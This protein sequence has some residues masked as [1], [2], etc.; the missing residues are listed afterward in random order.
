MNA[1][2]PDTLTMTAP[3]PHGATRE[4]PP[5][6]FGPEGLDALLDA[7]RADGYTTVGPRLRDGAVVYDAITR[8]ADLP[9]GWQ[10]T[11]EPASSRLAKTGGRTFFGVT[12]GAHPWKRFFYPPKTQVFALRRHGR[13]FVP[14][15]AVMAPAPRYALIG[16]RACELVAIARQD[17]VLR[18]GFTPDPLYT[19][20]RADSFIV[21]VN[22]TR[23]VSTCFCVSQGT[24]PCAQ[25]GY[26]LA[27]TEL[28]DGDR[29]Q[30][31]CDIGTARGA[32]VL[33]RISAKA[34]TAT[35]LH[36]AEHARL[37]A[38]AQTRRLPAAPLLHDTLLARAEHPHWDDIARRCMSCGACTVSCPTCF[39]STT[40]DSTDIPGDTLTRWRLWDSCFSL[41]FSYI[42]GGSV[43][44]SGR[45]RYRQWMTHKLATW[46]DQFGSSGCVGC[47]RCIAWCP[48][49]IDI[50]AEAA[51]LTRPHEET[52]HAHS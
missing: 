6:V 17:R 47:G 52:V 13:S 10:D 16:P 49:G 1:H 38:E 7:L 42:H 51:A 4:G 41:D 14:V 40:T 11:Q 15:D 19:Q 28:V 46:I 36:D 44:A 31:V 8:Y 27:L 29:H 22:C 50:T 39:C 21:A 23:C 37:A 35:E 45:S 18:D 3:A 24:G 43:R 26:D 12:L 33:A 48:V 9:I 5:H 25:S 30:F 20:R 32:A 34:A 2:P